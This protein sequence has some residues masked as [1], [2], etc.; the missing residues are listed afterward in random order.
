M[1]MDIDT[2]RKNL[3]VWLDDVNA[4]KQLADVPSNHEREDFSAAYAVA[5]GKAKQA[6][7]DYT[8]AV[9]GIKTPS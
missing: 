3:H 6:A 4:L 1:I 9:T 2:A 5:F 8:A 7:R